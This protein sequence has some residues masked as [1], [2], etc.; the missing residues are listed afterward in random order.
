LYHVEYL[1]KFVLFLFS[2]DIDLITTALNRHIAFSKTGNEQFV[3]RDFTGL[4]WWKL[5]TAVD[6]HRHTLRNFNFYCA[7]PNLASSHS[8]TTLLSRRWSPDKWFTNAR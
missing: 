1:R 6:Q 7:N 8:F 2:I 4:C 3:S 5:G